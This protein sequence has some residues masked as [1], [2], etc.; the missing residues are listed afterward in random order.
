MGHSVRRHVCAE[1]VPAIAAICIWCGRVRSVGRGV[2]AIVV[3]FSQHPV[4]KGLVKERLASAKVSGNMRTRSARS[5]RMLQHALASGLW[6]FVGHHVISINYCAFPLKSM[7]K[8]SESAVLPQPRAATSHRTNTAEHR[9][10]AECCFILFIC[11]I[12]TDH[13]VI[14]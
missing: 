10:P 5:S 7:G 1:T 13:F 3:P 14:L 12:Q 11:S 2:G 6:P 4:T 9:A 8:I